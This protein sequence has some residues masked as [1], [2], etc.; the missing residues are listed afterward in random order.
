[1]KKSSNVEWNEDTM[2]CCVA[3]MGMKSRTR[4]KRLVRVITVGV[5]IDFKR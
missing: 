4:P 2:E 3:S 5:V 1:M